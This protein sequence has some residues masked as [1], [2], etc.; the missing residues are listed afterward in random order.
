MEAGLTSG[1]IIAARSRPRWTTREKMISAA[2]TFQLSIVPLTFSCPDFKANYLRHVTKGYKYRGHY[3]AATLCF[4]NLCLS[5]Q[6]GE[7]H[8]TDQALVVVKFLT[9]FLLDLG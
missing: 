5:F 1:R 6:F 8:P 3:S 9:D 4:T 7:I 2:F